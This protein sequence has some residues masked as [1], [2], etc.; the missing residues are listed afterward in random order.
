MLQ[1]SLPVFI[2]CE[3]KYAKKLKTMCINSTGW[4]T[5]FTA[6]HAVYV[7]SKQGQ[8]GERPKFG[9]HTHTH[10]V[11]N[12][13]HADVSDLYL[14][15][16][17]ADIPL[18]WTHTRQAII[19]PCRGSLIVMYSSSSLILYQMHWSLWTSHAHWSTHSVWSQPISRLPLSLSHSLSVLSNKDFFLNL[20]YPTSAHFG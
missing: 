17:N 3:G 2:I 14:C 9:A 10:T 16:Y 8:P 7:L 18:S 5:E 1:P 13:L 15:T 19:R 6:T 12:Q 20:R 4:H 11:P